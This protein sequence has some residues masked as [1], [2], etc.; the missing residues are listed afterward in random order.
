MDMRMDTTEENIVAP[1]KKN[2]VIAPTNNECKTF[3]SALSS[4]GTDFVDMRMDATEENIVGPVK[5]CSSTDKKTTAT[6]QQVDDVLMNHSVSSAMAPGTYN[7]I[8]VSL[9]FEGSTP[10]T[11]A[12]TNNTADKVEAVQSRSHQSTHDPVTTSTSVPP[13]FDQPSTLA[14]H[15]VFTASSPAPVSFMAVQSWLYPTTAPVTAST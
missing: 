12:A 14:V 8:G 11:T 5:S 7:N 13:Q 3:V 10:T 9:W 4:V 15:N 1:A 6:I 2:E